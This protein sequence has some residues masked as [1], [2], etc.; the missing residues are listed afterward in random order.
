MNHTNLPRRRFA[1]LVAGTGLGLLGCKR[2]YDDPSANPL[3]QQV[4]PMSPEQEKIM[5]AR[6]RMLAKFQG[7]DGVGWQFGAKAGHEFLGVTFFREIDTER[8]FFQ[9][10]SLWKKN[11]IDGNE[12]VSAGPIAGIPEKVRVVWREAASRLNDRYVGKIIG[13]HVIDVGLAVPDAVIESVRTKGGGLELKFMLAPE[14]CY[15]GWHIWRRDPRFSEP[16]RDEIGGN[17]AEA[18]FEGG[19]DVLVKGWY[20]DPRTG[21]KVI[22]EQGSA[23]PPPEPKREENQ[24]NSPPCGGT[25]DFG[26]PLPPN[27]PCNQE[28][29]G[30]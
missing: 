2:P 18:L 13:E 24:T 8:V 16:I 7:L 10:S 3:G 17:F 9:S 20:I 25:D 29:A 5:A 23:A 27:A 26:R 22:D 4:E 1:F 19:G 30:R 14:T 28:R 12:R 11:R 6:A 15:F 21:L